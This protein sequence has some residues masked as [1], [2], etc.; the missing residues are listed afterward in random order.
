MCL[1]NF[2]HQQN[3]YN[4]SHVH[5][6]DY[7]DSHFLSSKMF[8]KKSKLKKNSI[9]PCKCF[10]KCHVIDPY[11]VNTTESETV[12]VRQSESETGGFINLYILTNYSFISSLFT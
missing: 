4:R 12:R 3:L 5:N 6:T 7:N 2:C 8:F 11:S 1:N 10:I 9:V